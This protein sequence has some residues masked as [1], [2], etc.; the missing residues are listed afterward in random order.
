MPSIFIRFLASIVFYVVFVE[1]VVVYSR[2]PH[3]TL[4]LPEGRVIG[5]LWWREEEK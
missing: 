2:L 4:L 1:Q 5:C 3:D